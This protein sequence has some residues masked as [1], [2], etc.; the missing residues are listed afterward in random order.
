MIKLFDLHRHLGGSLSPEFVYALSNKHQC[1]YSL[2]DIRKSMTYQVGD[3]YEF[4]S[5]M[6][7]FDI[8]NKI[9]WDE[10]DIYDMAHHVVGGLIREGIEYSEIRFT[11][12]KY[13]DHVDMS[14]VDLIKHV[15]RSFD[16][17]QYNS[18]VEVRL[19]F[20][21][22]Y[23]ACNRELN[24]AMKVG[25]FK[26]DVIGIDFV[27]DEGKFDIKMMKMV[28]KEWKKYG[29]GVVLHAGESQGSQNVRMAVEHLKPH[30]IAHGIRVPGEDSELLDMCRDAGICFDVAITSNILTGVVD[31]TISHPATKMIGNGNI[32]TI[33][34]DD[35]EVCRTTLQKEYD[36]AQANWGL[37]DEE[38]DNIKLN[39]IR[40]A[41][42]HLL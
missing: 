5:F 4:H 41:L 17:A 33:G 34:T 6:R 22:K 3:P 23:E 18:G 35:P 7:K 10:Q 16:D 31:S 40:M 8:L 15:R 20:S 39:S 37:T 32:I 11:I 30:R 42:V 36:L 9:K 29:L 1:G 26:D 13:L 25:Q 28:V 38:I 14:D 27:G 12:N 21:L 24:T 2:K 19:I